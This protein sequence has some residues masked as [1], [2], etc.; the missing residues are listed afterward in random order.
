MRHG[1]PIDQAIRL[2][3]TTE[4][5]YLSRCMAY[6]GAGQTDLA[7][8]D[9]DEALRQSPGWDAVLYQRP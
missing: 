3:P 6:L 2:D 1:Y 5:A 4:G 8:R 9:C 7:I